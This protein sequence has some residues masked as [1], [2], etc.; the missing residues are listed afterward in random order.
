MHFS[1]T[2]DPSR[3]PTPYLGTNPYPNNYT[4]DEFTASYPGTGLIGNRLAWMIAPDPSEVFFG[5][6]F[7]HL[8]ACTPSGAGLHYFDPTLRAYALHDGGNSYTICKNQIIDSYH[9]FARYNVSMYSSSQQYW[10]SLDSSAPPNPTN[11]YYYNQYMEGINFMCDDLS[12]YGYQ[13]GG[14]M[15]QNMTTG[16]LVDRIAKHYKFD[17]ETGQ[18]I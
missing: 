15:L 1:S 18:D 17:P 4:V 11:T 13:Y 14:D 10:L 7:L 9:K 16:K 8:W 5:L 6:D 2:N 12:A 3:P